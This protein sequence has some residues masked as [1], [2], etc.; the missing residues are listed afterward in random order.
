M[1]ESCPLGWRRARLGDFCTELVRRAESLDLP[2]LSVGKDYGLMLQTERFGKRLASADTA[3]YKKV[4]FGDFAYDAF[5]LW[6]GSIGRQR[7]ADEGIVSPAY[8]VFCVSTDVD[9]DFVEVLLRS[10]RLLSDYKRISVGTNVRRRKAAFSSFSSI[11]CNLPPLAEQRE[12]ASVLRA[13][14]DSV[15]AGEAVVDQLDTVRRE[16]ATTL[17]HTTPSGQRVSALPQGWRES[18]VGAECDTTSGG[19]PSRA[20]PS[21]WQGR[22]PWVKT[23]EVNYSTIY[24]TEES[25]TDAGVRNSAAHLVAAGAVIIAMYGQGATRGRCALL[26]IDAALNQACLALIPA[27]VNARFLFHY[28]WHIYPS[29]R[30][31]GHEGTQKNL[32]SSLVRGITLPVP[33]PAEQCRIAEALSEVTFRAEAERAVVAQ[34][35]A[36]KTALADALLSGKLRVRDAE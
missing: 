3:K 22:I 4:R 35:S 5:L 33:P 27:S 31:L 13:A 11:E 19:T 23:G 16:L 36:A 26:G 25:L 9:A 20:E 14:N 12:I 28:L 24:C 29:I 30:E 8:S 34:R 32:N 18:S 17:F 1:S 7:C 10:N 21:Y 2:V 15:L 6:S